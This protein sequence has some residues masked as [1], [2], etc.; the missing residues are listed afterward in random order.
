[1]GI[2]Q[3]YNDNLRKL[4]NEYGDISVMVLRRVSHVQGRITHSYGNPSAFSNE[5][6]LIGPSN[7]AGK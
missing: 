4:L 2:K 6:E 3:L 1:M 5:A 7:N